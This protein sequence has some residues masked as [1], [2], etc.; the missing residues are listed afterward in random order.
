MIVLLFTFHDNVSYLTIPV[1][2]DI[3]EKRDFKTQYGYMF[4][5]N[6]TYEPIVRLDDKNMKNS[7][8]SEINAIFV[9]NI[10]SIQNHSYSNRN[11]SVNDELITSI[12]AS[13]DITHHVMDSNF[14]CCGVIL[15]NNVFVP[16]ET[17]HSISYDD[18]KEL[19]YLD[20]V[21][22]LKPKI[23]TNDIKDIYEKLGIAY[24]FKEGVFGFESW[25]FVYLGK[26]PF[27]KFSL[28]SLIGIQKQEDPDDYLHV[29]R[30]LLN[31]EKI[32]HKLQ[33]ELY[34][35]KHELNPLHDNDKLGL[36]QNEYNIRD[37]DA[38]A[39]LRLNKK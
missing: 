38:R 4:K 31:D 33:D 8:D 29:V 16:F 28:M 15:S 32:K 17:Y 6:D 24:S 37:I 34:Y 21:N 35:L 36:L 12:N 2:Y 27:E 20:N 18:V 5:M 23:S 10:R 1:N 30:T 13:Y 14:K 26:G 22:T 9:S 25:D 11:N 3:L 39:L 7:L 19:M